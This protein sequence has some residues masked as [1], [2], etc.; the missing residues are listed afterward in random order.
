M[1]SKKLKINKS[2][3]HTDKAVK[4]MQIS[5]QFGIPLIFFIGLGEGGGDSGLN[6]TVYTNSYDKPIYFFSPQF[7]GIPN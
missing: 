7:R 6:F 1:T 5:N 4:L 3:S 2:L